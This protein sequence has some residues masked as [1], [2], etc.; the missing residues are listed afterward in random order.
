[1]SIFFGGKCQNLKKIWPIRWWQKIIT[2]ASKLYH[3]GQTAFGIKALQVEKS[4]E[5][6]TLTP[7]DVVHQAFSLTAL[8]GDLSSDFAQS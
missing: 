2:E 1:M 6:D 5:F 4:Y 3:I 8:H 7:R